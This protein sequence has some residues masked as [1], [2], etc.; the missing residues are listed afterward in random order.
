VALIHE[1]VVRELVSVEGNSMSVPAFLA[2]TGGSVLL[3]HLARALVVSDATASRWL[4][5]RG[6]PADARSAAAV[7]SYVRR[8]RWSRLASTSLLI[9][10]CGIALSTGRFWV[11]FLSLPFLLSV[12]LAE[13]LAPE[14]R[15]GRLRFG[16][17]ERRPRDY[18]AP[19]PHARA[20]RVGLGAAFVI[21]VS[22]AAAYERLTVYLAAHAVVVV[23]GA[24][25][26]EL[27]LARTAMRA[28][29]DR[30]PDLAL[31]TAM[32]VASAR[33]ATA[34]ALLFTTFGLLLPAAAFLGELSPGV[35]SAMLG[36]AF[37]NLVPL[38]AM[39]CAVN[40]VQPLA[41]WRPRPTA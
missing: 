36:L 38:A 30:Q 37:Y 3:V 12:L 17:L 34:A 21:S 2:L 27:G 19:A 23:V 41:S 10:A 15:R 4:E 28:L 26:Y 40:L 22:A 5:R 16:L 9:A 29:P 39:G 14:P 6:L 20:V 32:R 33:T 18:V 7:R 25:A 11:S 35:L 24:A 1:P 8:L 13:V 31:D